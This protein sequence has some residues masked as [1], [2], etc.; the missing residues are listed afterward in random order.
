MRGTTMIGAQDI[1]PLASFWHV[2][3]AGDFNRDGDA[4]LLWQNA[5]GDLV[6]WMLHRV[7]LASARYLYTG[8]TDWRVIDVTPLTNPTSPP[9]PPDLLCRAPTG[10]LGA[11]LLGEPTVTRRYVQVLPNP[12]FPAST[13]RRHRSAAAVRLLLIGE[14]VEPRR[15]A[16][17]TVTPYNALSTCD[18][19]SVAEIALYRPAE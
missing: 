16:A 3:G 18:I 15:F 8:G 11:W 4:D 10:Q 7:T 5:A 14:P 17:R 9:S 19:P 13:Y 1:W 2:V 6:M 12:L